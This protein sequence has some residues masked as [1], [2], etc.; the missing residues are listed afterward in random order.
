[1]LK[2]LIATCDRILTPPNCH[3]CGTV[4]YE[5]INAFD[6]NLC[7]DCAQEIPVM[8][9][10]ACPLCG[11]PVRSAL[12]FRRGRCPAC[13]SASWG[14]DSLT[15]CF[16]Y[17]G[18]ARSLIHQFKYQGRPYLAGTMARLMVT[19]IHKESVAVFDGLVPVP[20]FPARLREREFNQAWV[21]AERLSRDVDVPVLSL[22]ERVKNTRS[23][24]LLCEKDRRANVEGAFRVFPG[25][26]LS[27]QRLLLVDDILTT[28]AT[29]GA[30]AAAL[31]EAGAEHVAVL[32]FAKG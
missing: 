24:A 11:S 5:P 4:L 22:L 26:D 31:K 23:Q 9:A 29:A 27:G 1:M 20:L 7:L 19:V 28:G 3:A 18:T 14:F 17:N 16:S 10:N 6:A 30:A 13:R 2:E 25:Q 15:A 32:A 12:D 8:P 21:L